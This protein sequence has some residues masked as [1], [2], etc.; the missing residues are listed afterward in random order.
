MIACFFDAIFLK[1]LV[2]K[3]AIFLNLFTYFLTISQISK[4]CSFARNLRF[5]FF[6]YSRSLSRYRFVNVSRANRRIA[7]EGVSRRRESFFAKSVPTRLCWQ[8]G[9]GRGRVSEIRFHERN[10]VCNLRV[11]R[12]SVRLWRVPRLNSPH[13]E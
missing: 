2:K 4:N 12:I 5:F 7:S 3:I 10:P 9:K 8:I 6:F 1:V 13:Q 11:S